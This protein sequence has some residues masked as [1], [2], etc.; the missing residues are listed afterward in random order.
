MHTIN[1]T[2]YANLILTVVAVPVLV[3]FL[4][5]GAANAQGKTKIRIAT[6]SPSLSYLPIYTAVKK[7]FFAK[8]GFDVEMIQMSASLTAPALLN[9]SID[10]TTIPSTIAT[11]T[12][13]G[14]PAKVIFFASVKL[15]HVL[16]ARPD[17]ATV[18]DL[19][20]KRIAASGYG[21]LTA[22]EI[23]YVID[24]YKLGSNTTIVSV[25]SSTDR[26]LALQKGI[27]DAAI[28]SAPLDLKG[29]EMGLKGLL[30]MGTIL[31][32]P[33]AG[34][35]TTDEKLKTRRSE[36]IEV[37]KAGIEGLEYTHG[38]REDSSAIISKWMG[39]TAAQGVKAYASVKDTFSRNGVPTDEQSRAYIAMLAATAG[40]NA[41]LAPATIFDFSFA[42]AAAKE[43]AAKK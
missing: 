34:L 29:E 31:Q 9:R 7:G 33:Q 24:R 43:L 15:Q 27:A 38:E 30:H 1:R 28:I 32:I 39:L 13:R 6:A 21:N 22:Y 20:G 25:I 12:A 18:N 2:N 40:V 10:Y 5:T 35:A 26:L 36:V 16:L 17:I 19:A 41:E 23:Q 3:G 4:T 14:A 37:L 11:A 8:R 42:A